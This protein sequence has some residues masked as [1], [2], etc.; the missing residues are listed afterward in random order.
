MAPGQQ[1]TFSIIPDAPGAI[2]GDVVPNQSRPSKRPMTT[3][4]AKKAYQKANQGPKLS[5]A[6][7]RRQEL[8]EQDRIRKEFEK[9]KNQARAKAARDKKRE[10]EEKERAE[11]KKKGLPL[12]D[13]HPSQDTIAWF[14]RGDG[15]KKQEKKQ[16]ESPASL[17]P[18]NK[19]DSDSCTLSS[20]EDEPERASKRQKTESPVPIDP[21]PGYDPGSVRV[22]DDPMPV[23]HT[24]DTPQEAN[25]PIGEH[26]TLEHSNTNVDESKTIDLLPDQILVELIEA[27]IDS[28]E[29]EE[30]VLNQHLSQSRHKSFHN[31]SSPPKPLGNRL[32]SPN[33]IMEFPLEQKAEDSASPSSVQR[34]LRTL[35]SSEVNRTDVLN[36]PKEPAPDEAKPVIPTSTPSI[37]SPKQRPRRSQPSASASRSFRHPKTPMG[38]P[39]VPPKFRSRNHVPARDSRTSPF[40]LKQNHTPGF[41]SPANPQSR[42]G[43]VPQRM[44]EEYPPTSTQLFMLGHLDDFFPSPSQEVRELFE[45][46]NLD[47]GTNVDKPQTRTMCLDLSPVSRN[48]PTEPTPTISNLDGLT[49]LVKDSKTKSSPIQEGTLP[50]QVIEYPSGPA[51]NMQF[52]GSS[53]TFDMPFFSTQDFVLSSQDMK[54]LEDESISPLGFKRGQRNL[55][56]NNTSTHHNAYLPKTARDNTNVSSTASVSRPPPQ[57]A[58]N[59]G[60]SSVTRTTGDGYPAARP[61]TSDGSVGGLQS[62]T[63]IHENITLSNLQAGENDAHNHRVRN[64]VGLPQ[65]AESA[66]RSTTKQRRNEPLDTLRMDNNIAPRSSPKPFLASSGR[67]AQ[68]KYVL[69]RSKTTSWEGTVTRQK[70]Q[71]ELE[72]FQRLEDERSSRLLAELV[73]DDIDKHAV[74]TFTSS[75]RPK[76]RESIPPPHN[77]PKGPSQPRSINQLSSSAG[78][79]TQN[80]K[81]DEPIEKRPRQNP[82]RSSYEE[83]LEMLKR[84]ENQKQEQQQQQ[85]QQAIP[86]SQETDYGEAGLDDVLSEML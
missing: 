4:Q 22:V 42:E 40:L 2:N 37:D 81:A 18:I 25:D 15:K 41:S 43:H 65:K 21:D 75:S 5:K 70:A 10:K 7:R 26:S 1:N 39:P 53:E 67:E 19:D 56:P 38:P 44:R 86:A 31:P 59:L 71:E 63:S 64:R 24:E 36:T 34:P 8:F 62:L 80:Q 47:I 49:A 73:A 11:K 32:Q 3:K 35:S 45:D 61:Y 30:A 83:M 23:A 14:V 29:R 66:I 54:D 9:E 77:Q 79:N 52:S 78:R 46:P 60:L 48:L 76:P 20:G 27:T 82:S 72:Q 74:D 51:T 33:P 16:V 58:K 57:Q 84:K 55:Q 85:Q 68:Y 69:E 17:A 50:I 6:E 12:V 13:V 28:P